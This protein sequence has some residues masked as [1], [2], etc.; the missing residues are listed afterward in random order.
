MPTYYPDPVRR[1]EVTIDGSKLTVKPT[2]ETDKSAD[3]LDK[4]GPETKL[5]AVYSYTQYGRT[6]RV[7]HR[8][9][10]AREG[11][12]F[13]LNSPWSERFIK[14]MTQKGATLT[15]HTVTV[16]YSYRVQ[17]RGALATSTTTKSTQPSSGIAT[18]TVAPCTCGRKTALSDG[19]RTQ[20]FMAG[21]IQSALRASRI[22]PTKSAMSCASKRVRNQGLSSV[23]QQGSKRTLIDHECQWEPA[24]GEKVRTIKWHGSDNG[25]KFEALGHIRYDAIEGLG[26]HPTSN[27][28]GIS[29]SA[30]GAT[31]STSMAKNTLGTAQS[32]HQNGDRVTFKGPNDT[33]TY[34]AVNHY[35]IHSDRS[36]DTKDR[37]I[38]RL[39]VGDKET[40]K[41]HGLELLQTNDRLD[42]THYLAESDE[43]WTYYRGNSAMSA[44]YKDIA[45]L[46]KWEAPKLDKDDKK[47][48]KTKR[49][50][51]KA[52]PRK[53]PKLK[54]KKKTNLSPLSWPKTALSLYGSG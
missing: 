50:P 31:A 22:K 24:G 54:T 9:V 3:D 12:T 51:K 11:D 29:A 37:S 47:Q 45:Y 14:E 21:L 7:G 6:T 33:A 10:T 27:T 13:T 38:H 5:Y 16:P 40:A 30:L 42:D 52:R 8:H 28:P 43:G 48:K 35:Q 49:K 41:F 25:K 19:S 32:R 18:A 2:S 20:P 1:G 46:Q 26:R 39:V 15:L 17:R 23:I 34:Q 4:L 53:T 44:T 36:I